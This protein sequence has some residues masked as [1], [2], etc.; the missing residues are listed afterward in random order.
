MVRC[1][2]IVLTDLKTIDP[3]A[4]RSKVDRGKA[5]QICFLSSIFRSDRVHNCWI[6]RKDIYIDF[7]QPDPILLD[8]LA[9]DSL[10]IL[11]LLPLLLCNCPHHVHAFSNYWGTFPDAR[12]SYGTRSCIYSSFGHLHGFCGTNSRHAPLFVLLFACCKLLL[13]NVGFR[14]INYLD[15]VAY[16]FES[17]MINEFHGREFPCATL[18]PSGNSYKGISPDQRV[19]GTVGSQAGSAFVNGDAY[20]NTSFE[21]YHSHL[22][23]N[24]GII[25]A[26]TVGFCA[27]YLS[28]TEFIS[29]GRSKGEVLL[30]R[31]GMVP[32]AAKAADVEEKADDRPTAEGVV[33]EKTITGG[34]VPPSIQKQT[35]IFHWQAVNY[36]IKIKSE[37]RRLLDDV[38]GW[39]KPGTLTAVSVISNVLR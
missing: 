6:A 8:K 10:R 22:W 39:V 17:L 9:K 2:L 26:M 30:F 36:D 29:A 11:H 27:I 4:L 1:F 25:F 3:Y 14:W 38:D 5:L 16:A 20:I 32:V 13:T 31:R 19:C 15:P 18:I 37:P 21:Y 28:A 33:A 12:S 34:E 35:A 7:F 23:R 24:L